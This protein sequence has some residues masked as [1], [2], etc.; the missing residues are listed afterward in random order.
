MNSILYS[1]IAGAS[2]KAFGDC[3]FDQ[4]VN[5][6]TGHIKTTKTMRQ[7]LILKI[8][9][10]L[11]AICGAFMANAQYYTITESAA[12][13]VGTTVTYT[14]TA[15]FDSPY[16]SAAWSISP[17]L[18]TIVSTGLKNGNT[19]ATCKIKWNDPGTATITLKNYG[20]IIDT[21]T[22]N[23]PC[24]VFYAALN[25]TTDMLYAPGN[26][27]LRVSVNVPYAN[28][29]E[30]FDTPTATGTPLA[31]GTYYSPYITA[32]KTY[33]VR[34]TN[35]VT[36]CKSELEQVTAVLQTP[37]V[38]SQIRSIK[39]EAV[40]S[41]EVDEAN[42]A[43]LSENN[44]TTSITYVDGLGRSSQQIVLKGTA[45]GNDVVQ[46]F[47]YNARGIVTKA[48]LPY[49][50]TTSTSGNYQT[51]YKA[52]QAA[53]Y[54]APNDKIANENYP[55]ADVAYESSPLGRVTEQ[56]NFL[57]KVGSGKTNRVTYSYNTGATN[58]PPEEVRKFDADGSNTGFYS[59][60]TLQ[61]ITVIDQ[62]GVAE[63]QF[64]DSKGL[65]IAKKRQLDETINGT[66]VSYLQT[67]Y[68]YDEFGRLKYTITP[69]GVDKLRQGSW[70]SPTFSD[71]K[72]NYVHQFT[73]DARGRIVEKKTPGQAAMY[74]VYD[75]YNRLVLAQDG[76]L[77][78][79]NKWLFFK[80]DQERR[81]VMQGFY[82]TDAPN[83][84]RQSMQTLADGLYSATNSTYPTGARFETRGSAVQGYTNVS[85]PKTNVDN[86]ALEF[87]MV[88]YYDDYDFDNNGTSDY[89]YAVQ[90]L[91]GENTVTKYTDG[92]MTGSKRLI[93]GTTTWLTS[94]I[95][96]ND[97]LRPIQVLSNNHLSSTLNNLFT[98]VYDFEG[99]LLTTKRYHNAGG[100]RVTTVVNTY[101][102]DSKGRLLSVSQKNN[103]DADRVVAQYEYNEIGQ[104]VDK[105][106]HNVSGS[107]FLQSVDYRYN[108][109]GWLESIN[110][111]SLTNDSG[112]KNDETNDYFGMELLY[113]Q[114]DAGLNNTA[115][116]NGLITG[117]KIKGPGAS[118][119]V[120]YTIDQ[121]G[122]NFNYDKQGQLKA[123]TTLGYNG[124]TWS[125][126]NV[127]NET[128]TYDHN[129][130]IL[131][132]Q[133]T[134]GKHTLTGI[135]P[136]YVSETIDDLT[137]SYTNEKL[138][139]VT[140]AAPSAV[141]S[142]GFNNGSTTTDNDFT[143]DAAGSV[144]ADGNKGISSVTYNNLGRVESVNFS[145]GRIVS[146]SYDAGGNKLTVKTYQNNATL[147][148]TTDYV[149]GFVYEN[150]TLSFFGAPEGRVVNKSGA[151]EH[152]YMIKDHQGNTRLVFT[153]AT[154]AAVAPVATFEGDANDKSGEYQN[155]N[156]S[157]VVTFFAANNTSGGNK[158]IR[159]NQNYKVG[160]SK[161]LKVYPGDA[162]DMEVFA[163]YESASGYGT[164][165][166]SLTTMITSIAGAF[167]G[168]SG[169][170]GESGAIYSGVNNCLGVF[171][172]GANNGDGEPAAYL[173]YILFDDSY[174][175]LYAGWSRV[176]TTANFAKQ[177]VSIPTKNINRP[178]YVFAYL[179]YENLSDNYVYFDDFKVTHTKTNIIQYNEYYAFGMQAA[180]S[181]TRDD[182]KNNF[183][184]NDGTELNLTTGWY[185]TPFRG[186][187]PT[188]GRFMQVDPLAHRDLWH[189][190]YLYGQNSPINLNDPS[191]LVAQMTAASLAEFITSA[192]NGNGGVWTAGND[193]HMFSVEEAKALEIAFSATSGSGDAGMGATSG[194]F[195]ANNGDGTGYG[196][197][198]AKATDGNITMV[199]SAG[200][201]VD[202]GIVEGPGT[203]TI[204]MDIGMNA[205]GEYS[206]DVVGGSD[207]FTWEQAD[208]YGDLVS[209]GAAIPALVGA[210]SE[211]EIALK[212][213]KNA[214]NDYYAEA[215]SSI[216]KYNKVVGAV[217]K[218]LGI[219]GVV[220]SFGE[221]MT[222]DFSWTNLAKFGINVGSLALKANP[223]G[224]TVSLTI[225]LLDATGYLE[226]GLN[227]AFNE[228][229]Q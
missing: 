26:I 73:Y 130:N 11:V 65:L 220:T 218:V 90:S 19:I 156:A 40:R 54:T 28:V 24:P 81:P 108:I 71:I 229:T 144:I 197:M 82:S 29:V 111:S 171:G 79:S 117:M 131:T 202:G 148:T 27:D 34:V 163:Y 22:V 166:A 204:V 59:A 211:R 215:V 224:A 58:D 93:V 228:D 196:F 53:F 1:P 152:Q 126:S 187:D 184:Y 3:S 43:G 128:M 201:I 129:G 170:A 42:I 51:D 9:L 137:Y 84:S 94:Y 20:N 89:A 226:E 18:G 199:V 52:D 110:N 70:T 8:L 35:S 77:R 23:I 133:R 212:L 200:T 74:Y 192:L 25:T 2:E 122:Y 209:G 121:R 118:S 49:G 208:N 180:T 146:Y 151:L 45:L 225:G 41:R 4:P 219:A 186:Y 173:N 206:S 114:V 207:G 113:N 69:G 100:S 147:L 140:D 221:L 160:P 150:G 222:E 37:L 194:S 213:V 154:P 158:V 72:D 80:Y 169:G 61:K 183:L 105:K 136:S 191:G 75:I 50:T 15:E 227:W 87:I 214:Q 30:W 149:D 86:T 106:L 161:S 175:V 143:Y 13:A 157:N 177:K 68:I 12:P 36:G 142:L 7:K 97:Q 190:P 38:S 62:N 95:F 139:K 116:Y 159:M 162:I 107:T 168:V 188:L 88:S 10:T 21:H 134:R 125:Q 85:F 167:G 178:G 181:W 172:K 33:Y 182:S 195:I 210:I 60:N 223:I 16:N 112:T 119:N 124:T 165:N 155:V 96:Y 48:Y 47:E 120:P 127:M 55:F 44:R 103:N 179:S 115:K 5:K 76:K 67:Y 205:L 141:A 123:S 198:W 66:L 189:S 185:D 174:N 101:A 78:E 63:I 153:S 17:S 83:A 145:D 138:I 57:Y 193:P 6:K 14:I 46:P 132:L 104:M 56:G 164:T 32:T 99:K 39:T 203:K 102:Y 109:M 135:V 64:I 98:S 216:S 92:I 217:G 31:T 176:P 91:P